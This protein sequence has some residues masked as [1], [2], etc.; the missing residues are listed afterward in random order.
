M[1]AC[2]MSLSAFS[3]AFAAEGV[4]FETEG[5]P[6]ENEDMASLLKETAV[7]LLTYSEEELQIQKSMVESAENDAAV[8]MLDAIL[9]AKKEYGAIKGYGLRSC[10]GSRIGRRN[11]YRIHSYDL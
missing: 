3:V 9:E 5:T 1:A 7:R 4:P 2:L 11:L 8:S 10:P 6:V